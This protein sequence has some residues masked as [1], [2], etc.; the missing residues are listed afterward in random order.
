MVH[1]RR[2]IKECCKNGWD[3]DLVKTLSGLFPNS[4]IKLYKRYGL[5]SYIHYDDSLSFHPQAGHLARID[6]LWYTSDLVAY[7]DES[8]FSLAKHRLDV[9][10]LYNLI[11]KHLKPLYILSQ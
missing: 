10:D 3:D 11:P 4:I 6:E 7:F 5:F 1:R 8:K 2:L 9:P